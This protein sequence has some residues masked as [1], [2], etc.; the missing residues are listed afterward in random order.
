[1]EF[2]T[3][4]K[5]KA[6]MSRSLKVALPCMFE[7]LLAS[8]VTIADTIMVGSLGAVA[9]A[10][11]AI[12][13]SPS[14]FLNALPMIFS[15]GGTVLV[16]R[17]VGAEDYPLAGRAA[18]TAVGAAFSVSVILMLVMMFLSPFVPIW[19]GAA[20]EVIPDAINYLRI[21]SLA[22]VPQ[23]CGLTAAGLIRGAGNTKTPML[24]GLST[25]LV[26]VVVNFLLI[27]PARELTIFGFTFN[28][29]GAGM[30]VSGAAIATALSQTISGVFMV[31]LLF[32]NS[33]VIKISI[34]DMVPFDFKIMKRMV[35]V[36]LPAAAERLAI[37][38]GQIFFQRMIADLGT[39][40]VAAHYLATTAE[41]ITYMPAFGFGIAATTLVGQSLGAK[42]KEDARIYANIN[43]FLG[44]LLGVFCGL[45]LFIFPTQ[46]LSL[47]SNEPAVIAEG[48]GVIRLIAL[49]QPAFGFVIVLTGILR[50]AGDTKV[51][52]FAAV[53]G[54]WGIRLLFT[55]ILTYAFGFGL[56]GA[57]TAMGVDLFVRMCIVY[58]RFRKRTWLNIEV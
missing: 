23:F 57:W 28:M 1:M 7:N 39:I 24:V 2:V 55:W 46:L 27:F 36:G 37:S 16:A 13:A 32:N 35:R 53:F 45:L 20:P 48:S 50:G 31:M 47:F 30:G 40:Q 56:M 4:I 6:Y 5:R 52:L 10:A 12:N 54:M 22:I 51:P 38:I 3:D 18:S 41:S 11:V 15:V 58:S 21:Y 44:I 43:G 14:W 9:T 49:V 19:M 42:N 29:W 25:N 33:Q 34:K 26:N 8:V 17:E